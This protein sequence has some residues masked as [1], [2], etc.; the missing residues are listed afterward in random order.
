MSLPLLS[1]P[2]LLKLI[3]RGFARPTSRTA[4]SLIPVLLLSFE[5]NE[6]SRGFR[7]KMTDLREFT[8]GNQSMERILEPVKKRVQVVPET[9][10]TIQPKRIPKV[11]RTVAY[12]HID[13]RITRGETE[14]NFKNEPVKR[15]RLI[16][17]TIKINCGAVILSCCEL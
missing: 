7:R 1:D 14:R 11:Q 2:L 5:L 15:R 10:V 9:T 16:S 3:F 4:Q 8:A 12:V 6:H 13:I 17:L